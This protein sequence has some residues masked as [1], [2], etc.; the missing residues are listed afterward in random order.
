LSFVMALFFGLNLNAQCTP[1]ANVD[2]F[3]GCDGA[4]TLSWNAVPDAQSY[5]VDIEN[6]APVV[7]FVNMVTTTLTIE[8]G[9]L[10]PG[11]TYQFAITANCGVSDV[12]STQGTI[13]GAD[14]TNAQPMI[15]ISNVTS[16]YCPDIDATG[17]FDV[18]IT[19]DGC[20]GTYEVFVDGASV[21]TGVASGDVTTVS[22]L[23]AAVGGTEYVV[24]IEAEAGNTCN[25]TN[26]DGG[27]CLDNV[28]AS[29]TLTPQDN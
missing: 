24:T 13:T 22:G 16:P 8:P 21:A 18:V 5:T 1:P 28:S 19:D 17:E 11:T 12:S 10:T 3:Y 23:T 7:D 9:T 27:N 4:V 26:S 20:G 29:T 2:V 15:A 6:G 25:Y 14:I